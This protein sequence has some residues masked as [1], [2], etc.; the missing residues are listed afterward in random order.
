ME[1]QPSVL[2]DGNRYLDMWETRLS[3]IVHFFNRESEK[4]EPA[5][6][7]DVRPP[8][9]SPFPESIP[10]PDSLKRF[11]DICDGGY[12][13][14]AINFIPVAE[15]VSETQ[16]WMEI[17]RDYDERGDIITQGQQCVFANDPDG[18]PWIYDRVSGRVAAFY[19]KGGD[20]CDPKFDTH[21]DFMI[22]VLS[23]KPNDNDWSTMLT[24]IDAET[25]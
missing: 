17:L 2:G 25:K 7:Y 3:T 23:P 24:V 16:N 8:A 13:G 10:A 18:A 4:P 11:Y 20:W 14:P 1:N 15:L 21:D 5:F 6:L 9:N 22:D 19:W 12:F